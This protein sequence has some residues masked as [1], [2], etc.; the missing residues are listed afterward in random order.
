MWVEKGRKTI[1]AFL[2]G[3]VGVGGGSWYDQDSLS[4]D[5]MMQILMYIVNAPNIAFE[6]A[7]FDRRNGHGR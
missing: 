1:A 2:M 7:V 5:G 4:F 3:K 6:I